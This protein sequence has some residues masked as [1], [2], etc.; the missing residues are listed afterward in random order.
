VGLALDPEWRLGPGEVHLTQ[1]GS[2]SIDEVNR[3]VTWLADLTRAG[4]LPQKLLVL[5]QFQVRMIPERERLDTSRDEL[6]VMVHADGQGTQGDKQ[7]TWQALRQT[8]PD[9][10]SWGWK[11]FY[12]EDAPML[13]PEETIAQVNPRPQLISYQ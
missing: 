8:D 4:D 10:V 2:V 13:T 7:A 12:D 3:V 5:H 6:A 1:I 9:A 11:N